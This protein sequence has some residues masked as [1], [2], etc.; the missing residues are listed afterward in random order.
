MR[1]IK[2]RFW[3]TVK[4]KWMVDGRTETSIYDFAFKKGMNWDFITKAEAI[5]RVIIEQYTGLTDKNGK[6]IYGGDEVIEKFGCAG[7]RTD[8]YTGIVVWWDSGWFLKTKKHGMIS[9][10]ASKLD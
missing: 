4:K 9:L 1:D 6:E 8:I 5:D 10:T 2:F 3:D 7:H